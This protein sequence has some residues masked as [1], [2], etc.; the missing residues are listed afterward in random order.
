MRY[1]RKK[2]M[3]SLRKKI[4]KLEEEKKLFME[5]PEGKAYKKRLKSDYQKEYRKNNIEK[6][7]KYQKEYATL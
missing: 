7:R 5:S 6:I 1:Y 3:D 4:K 2:T